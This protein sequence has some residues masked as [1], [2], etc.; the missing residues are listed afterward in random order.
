MAGLGAVGLIIDSLTSTSPLVQLNVPSLSLISLKADDPMESENAEDPEGSPIVETSEELSDFNTLTPYFPV[1]Y[2]LDGIA[3][4]T[5]ARPAKLYDRP[6]LG[7]PVITTVK[8]KTA[9][10]QL[11]AREHYYPVQVKVTDAKLVPEEVGALKV[12]QVVPVLWLRGEDSYRIF[13]DGK[14]KVLQKGLEQIDGLRGTKA[15]Y[16]PWGKV[17]KNPPTEDW[18]RVKTTDGSQGWL[19]DAS[20]E[21]A[22]GD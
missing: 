3:T 15:L 6:E 20:F 21:D 18:T 9:V 7:A 4:R 14:A 22:D 8:A 19:L 13:I 17:T 11:A 1:Q 16:D 2:N 5:L 10:E 12:G